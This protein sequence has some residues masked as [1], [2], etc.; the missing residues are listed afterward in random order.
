MVMEWSSRPQ[1][2]SVCVSVLRPDLPHTPVLL[3]PAGCRAA[4]PLQPPKSL[5]SA[6]YRGTC[7]NRVAYV[8]DQHIFQHSPEDTT[9]RPCCDAASYFTCTGWL[10]PG[11]QLCGWSAAAAHERRTSLWHAEVSDVWPQHQTPVSARHGL[12]AGEYMGTDKIIH[13]Y[14][15]I[16]S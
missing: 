8:Q 4:L 3:S 2:V 5:F 13:K 15:N 6:G 14:Y 12:S 1:S 7:C 11:Y 9:V 10:L 16:L